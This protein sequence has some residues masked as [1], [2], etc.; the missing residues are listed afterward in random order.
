MTETTRSL[1]ASGLGNVMII[2]RLSRDRELPAVHRGRSVGRARAPRRRLH[3]DLR[4][5][6][7]ADL[8]HRAAGALPRHAPRRHDADHA[9]LLRHQGQ[10]S[11][12]AFWV[13]PDREIARVPGPLDQGRARCRALINGD[14]AMGN[15]V[16]SRHFQGFKIAQKRRIE[17][18]LEV[19]PMIGA[20][21]ERTF[22]RPGLA[23][24]DEV[25]F[26]ERRRR[27]RRRGR[28]WAPTSARSSPCARRWAA[29]PGSAVGGHRDAAADPVPARGGA[30][31]ARAARRSCW[32]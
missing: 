11:Q 22:G 7:A 21:F 26:H 10:P 29:R 31:A 32:S 16:T 15:C 18:V 17:R 19:L 5:R 2:E 3:P 13:E 25:G 6:Q 24:F 9:R 4:A 8:R 14:T 28:A 30:Q 27:G 12:R 23:Y 1:G 20:D